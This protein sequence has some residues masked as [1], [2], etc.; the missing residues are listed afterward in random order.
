MLKP[1]VRIT[2]PLLAYWLPSLVLIDKETKKVNPATRPTSFFQVEQTRKCQE[3][4]EQHC[5]G[6]AGL[7]HVAS[8]VCE[9]VAHV[10]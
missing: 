3:V 10:Q 9:C 2:A 1:L 8:S 4:R 6:E 7:L 5:E